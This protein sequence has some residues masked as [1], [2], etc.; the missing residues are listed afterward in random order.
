VRALLQKKRMLPRGAM[1]AVVITQTA[2]CLLIGSGASADF[3]R[4]VGKDGVEV[5]TNTPAGSSAVRVMRE[6]NSSS[7]EPRRDRKPLGKVAGSA[8]TGGKEAATGATDSLL[9]VKG[10]VTSNY[11]WRHDPIDGGIRHHNGVDIAVP[12]GTR[13]KAIAAGTVKESGSHGGYGNLV[14]I[15]HGNGMVS[16]YG[17]NSQLEVRAG[18]QVQAGQT[19]ALSGS[20]GRST[21]PHLHFELWRNGVNVTE[22]YLNNGAGVPEV[23]GGIRTYLHKDGSIVFTNLR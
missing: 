19:V 8:G 2:L 12:I 9:P 22:A 21:G 6:G 20:T 4:Y 1:R 14:S 13:V 7:K 16:L 11:G 15:D 23:A 17:H 18:D 10:V 3:Y 5:F